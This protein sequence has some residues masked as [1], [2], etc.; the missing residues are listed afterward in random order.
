VGGGVGLIIIIIIIVV[1]ATHSSAAVAHTVPMSE[2][3]HAFT[4]HPASPVEHVKPQPTEYAIDRA[5]PVPGGEYS[6]SYSTAP[7]SMGVPAPAPAAKSEY[8]YHT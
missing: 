5:P 3:K 2:R 6:T 4:E 7:P 8:G 1:C